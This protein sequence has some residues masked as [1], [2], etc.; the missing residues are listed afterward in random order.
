MSDGC[1]FLCFPKAIT[2]SY[3]L[4]GQRKG[5]FLKSSLLNKSKNKGGSLFIYFFL[6]KHFAKSPGNLGQ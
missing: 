3:Y 2:Y 5:L 4:V 6:E 1:R